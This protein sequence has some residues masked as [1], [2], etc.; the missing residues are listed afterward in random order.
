[1]PYYWDGVCE[2]MVW[3]LLLSDKL[4]PED[5]EWLD[6]RSTKKIF[7]FSEQNKIEEL[8]IQIFGKLPESNNS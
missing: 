6:K 8:Y 2:S 3:K 5:R 4:V 7:R 1:M